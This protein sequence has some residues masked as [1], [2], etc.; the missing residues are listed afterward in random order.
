MFSHGNKGNPNKFT[1]LF[2]HWAAA[3]YIVAAPRFPRTSNVDPYE[4][5]DYPLQPGDISFVLTELLKGEHS[6]AIDTNRIAAAGLSL[7]GGTTY[8]LTYNPCCIDT[9]FRAAAV[10]DGLRFQFDKPFGVNKVP[11]LIMHIDPDA[12]LPYSTAV[13]SYNASASPK[14]LVT[15]LTGLHAEPFEDTPSIHDKTTMKV[16]TD[17]F[18][19][20]L[21][22][23]TAARERLLADGNVPKEA[24]TIAG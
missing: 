19:L 1:E 3:G 12:V 14:F 15:L 8:A 11:V 16:T 4:F 17:F 21:L 2:E 13:D 18:D 6:E 5:V 10:F 9:R 23:D 20:T 22:D 24:T 7:G